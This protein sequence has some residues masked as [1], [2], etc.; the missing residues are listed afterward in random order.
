VQEK[1]G[2]P[3]RKIKR[4][5]GKGNDENGCGSVG[6]SELAWMSVAGRK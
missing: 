6:G 3:R 4:I 1:Q 2:K 5:E